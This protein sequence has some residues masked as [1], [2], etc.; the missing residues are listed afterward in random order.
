MT[1]FGLLI[2]ICLGALLLIIMV[3]LFLIRLIAGRG[4][5]FVRKDRPDSYVH[6]PRGKKEGEVSV[7]SEQVS[8]E[9]KIIDDNIG[10][11]V[12]F[13]EIKD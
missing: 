3:P 9:D 11:Y 10:E 7:Q 6:R 13:E 5:G 12:D 2:F 4:Y 1:F 8:N